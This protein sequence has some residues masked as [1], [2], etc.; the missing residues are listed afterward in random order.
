M[1]ERM[2][3]TRPTLKKSVTKKVSTFH[4]NYSHQLDESDEF[5][6]IK[7]SVRKFINLAQYKQAFKYLTQIS[8]KYPNSYYIASMLAT[9]NAEDAFVLPEAKKEKIF[10]IAAKKLRQLLY[11]TKGASLRLK[12]RN[13]NE[14]YWF[15]E[16]PKKQYLFGVKLVGLGETNGLYSQGVGAG[17]YAYKLFTEGKFT[18]GLRWAHK[19]QLC[20]EEYFEKVAKDYHDPWYWYALA[21]GLQKKEKEMN[22]ALAKSAKLSKL[23]LEKD[24]SFKKMRKMV[25]VVGK[26]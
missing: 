18:L 22:F 26:I 8:T 10:E 4:K 19:S 9:L 2:R 25:S 7:N 21:L 13:I 20:W 16:Q 24:P 6:I 15:S 11:G 14:Y 12:S 5:L 17:N 1:E 3:N 23:N